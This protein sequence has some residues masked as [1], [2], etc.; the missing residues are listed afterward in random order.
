MVMIQVVL[1]EV[2]A[3]VEMLDVVLVLLVVVE[4]MTSCCSWR[5]TAR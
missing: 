5:C 4:V 2:Q 3:V 1:L